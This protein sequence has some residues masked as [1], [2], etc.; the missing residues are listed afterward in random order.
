MKIV[1]TSPVQHDDKDFGVGD[2]AD[3]PKEAAVMLVA[4]G[5]AVE[6]GKKTAAEAEPKPEA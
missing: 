1:F 5:A 6:A 4:C 3:L 2:T